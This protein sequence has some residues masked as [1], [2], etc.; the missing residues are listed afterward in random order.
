[1]RIVICL[2]IIF[3]YASCIL[4]QSPHGNGLT[5][6]C[7]YCH[8]STSWQ[9]I[10]AQMKFD[11][12]LETVFKLEGQHTLLKCRSCHKS[13]IFSEANSGCISCH[14]DVHQNSVGT[15]CANCHTTNSWIVT[16]IIDI[17]RKGRFPLLGVHLNVD[18]AQ[19]H[20]GY[21]KLY[22]PPQSVSC[23]SCHKKQYFD[24]AS[25]NHVVA[26]FST[27]CGECHGITDISWKT[28]KIDHS[29]FP[30]T[31]GHNI[32]NCFACHKSGSNFKG[33]TADCYPCHQQN[34]IQAKNPD[35]IQ[36]NF[37]VTCQ[38]CHNTISFL[39]STFDHSATGFALTGAHISIACKSCH[40]TGY[41]NLPT[42][43][44]SCHSADF[45][46]TTDPN[47]AAQ[48]FGHDCTQCHST[49][50]W[51]GANFDHTKTGFALTGA[52]ASLL[53]QSCHAS[54]YTNTPA[55]C[56]SCH[57]SDYN[58]TTNPN[59]ASA[60]FPHDCS[61][62]HSTTN[63]SGATFSHSAFPLTGSHN[64]ACSNCHQVSTNF[65]AHSCNAIC[66]KSAHHQDQDCYT[67][68]SN[69]RGDD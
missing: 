30:L 28:G 18:C 22:F 13:L 2:I 43:C 23:F 9:V 58:G 64:T 47:H 11:H 63:W 40:T 12:N 26:N 62:C 1:M 55:D 48:G 5:I 21:S 44:Y 67:C 49:A 69:G 14:K 56:Y 61:Q 51:A 37:P 29:F 25:P 41:T 66:H 7:S 3:A 53:C 10:P 36:A 6:D 17:H 15:D 54:G 60:G 4:P 42:D 59:H 57:S 8:E 46:A 31:G 39:Q 27:D 65:A 16:D 35:H 52:H 19:C 24:A 68:H 32:A 38:D 20:S 33:L 34:Y 45:N 50:G